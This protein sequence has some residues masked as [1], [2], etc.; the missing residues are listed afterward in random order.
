M[1]QFTIRKIDLLIH[2]LV[3]HSITMFDIFLQK[4]DR[5]TTSIDRRVC[6]G[7]ARGI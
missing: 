5:K 1:F 4:L 2:D 3:V 7:R 6:Q